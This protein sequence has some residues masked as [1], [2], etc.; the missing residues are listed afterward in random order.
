MVRTVCR[1]EI[2]GADFAISPRNYSANLVT[3]A[4]VRAI[5]FRLNIILVRYFIARGTACAR[6][7]NIGADRA[8]LISVC[9]DWRGF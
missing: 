1:L 8:N 7:M 9:G 4:A 3:A 5:Y 6:L 2:I